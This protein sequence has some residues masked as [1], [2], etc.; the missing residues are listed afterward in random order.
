F[1][2]EEGAALVEEAAARF[3][4]E[5]RRIGRVERAGGRR[6][7]IIAGPEGTLAWERGLP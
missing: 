5:A 3:S 2:C 4:V 1:A 7:L 6:E